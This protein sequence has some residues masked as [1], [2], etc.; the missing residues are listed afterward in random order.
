MQG[1]EHL[2]EETPRDADR[3]LEC[4]GY[5]EWPGEQRGDDGCGADAADELCEDGVDG[6]QRTDGA[7]QDER[8]RY[9]ERGSSVSCCA[10]FAFF[11][12]CGRLCMYHIPGR[13]YHGMGKA[14]CTRHDTNGRPLRMA[15]TTG[16]EGNDGESTY[17]WIEHGA[18]D[19]GE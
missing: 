2:E 16:K 5:R 6:A 1:K 19:F 17:R 3:R 15:Q 11:A 18:A 9:L 12:F 4:G 13:R 7:Y 14:G 10:G 8:E